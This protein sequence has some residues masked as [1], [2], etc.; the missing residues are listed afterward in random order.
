MIWS[1]ENWE[2]DICFMSRGNGMGI[3]HGAVT[4]IGKT[5]SSRLDFCWLKKLELMA[6]KSS[7]VRRERRRP[8]LATPDGNE[9]SDIVIF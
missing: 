4:L 3:F 8:F 6:M 2:V 9:A 7:R 1:I 5:W